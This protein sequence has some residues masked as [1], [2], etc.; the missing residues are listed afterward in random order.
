MDIRNICCVGAGVIGHSWA[1]LFAMRGYRVYL[2]DANRRTLTRALGLIRSNIEFLRHKG[3]V[4]EETTTIL[5]RVNTTTKLTEA[6]E[7]V[8]YIQESTYEKY[9]VK[10]RLFKEI[11]SAASKH[12]IL[13]SS[14]SGL[15][16]T[17]IQKVTASPE[18]CLIVHP[19]NP[20]H[21]IP[22]VE[23]VPGKATSA[24][25][26]QKTYQ[27]M[28]ELG[29]VPVTLKK[30]VPGYIANRLSAALWRE[31]IDL[32]ERDVASVEDVDKALCAGPGIRWA[33]MGAHLTYHLG[34]GTGGIRYFIDQLEPAFASWWRDMRV[35]T[36]IPDTATKKVIAGVKE[37]GIV[38]TR[39]YE[40]LVKWRD[41][42]LVDLLRIL[43]S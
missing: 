21:L 20:P 17:E 37:I 36:S 24:L 28:L 23:L 3:L 29:K 32:V 12:A 10:K 30:E 31:A 34:G 42:K 41:D 19:F 6:V 4:R 43:Y 22:L 15:L 11:E 26:I 40:D 8:D 16:M 38:R 9:T 1:T 7:S 35:W 33:I 25:T 39:K 13:A 27:F 2:Q 5:E 14:S 18:R